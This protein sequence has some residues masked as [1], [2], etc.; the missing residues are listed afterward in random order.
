MKKNKIF[1]PVVLAST[2]VLTT[3]LP[4][5]VNASEAVE[6][7]ENQLNGEEIFYSLES[8]NRAIEYDVPEE[9][10]VLPSN[11]L[12]R[13]NVPVDNSGVT[14]QKRFRGIT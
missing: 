7:E 4:T 14:A 2:L 3:I 6:Q 10:A 13:A 8:E 11:P 12:L 1:I 9:I 5:F